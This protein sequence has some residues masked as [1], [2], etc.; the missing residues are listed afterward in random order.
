MDSFPARLV[1]IVSFA[2][3]MVLPAA[4]A[5]AGQDKP[6]LAPVRPGGDIKPPVK[7]KDVKPIYPEDARRAKAQGVVI[8][9]ATVGADGK[10]ASVKVLRSIPLLDAAATN[11]VKQ[12][13]YKPTIVN[14]VAVPIIVTVPVIF[15]LE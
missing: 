3:L 11:S 9:E 12:Q 14:G 2:V 7:I 8:T 5:F 15:V 4:G 13:V 1:R 6:S 10:V